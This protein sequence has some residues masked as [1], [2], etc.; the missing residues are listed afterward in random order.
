MTFSEYLTY[1][2]P[3]GFRDELIHGEIVLSPS[4]SR[5]HSDLCSTLY[6][7]LKAKIHSDFLVRLDVTHH[8]GDKEGPRPDVFVISVERW[9]AAD[10]NDGYPE[11]GPEL[12][13][14][15]ISPSNTDEEMKSK[16]ELYFSDPRCLAVWEVDGVAKTITCYERHA[17]TFRSMDDLLLIPA[18]IGGGSIS[19]RDVFAGIVR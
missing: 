15:V 10:E 11:G 13:I 8:L 6:D 3:P 7:L 14:E 16:R 9:V 12:A 1:E 5:K 2:A 17:V 18:A 19:V 4:A